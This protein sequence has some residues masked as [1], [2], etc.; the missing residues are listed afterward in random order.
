MQFCCLPCRSFIANPNNCFLYLVRHQGSSRKYTHYS[1]GTGITKESGQSTFDIL[2]P[3]WATIDNH[4]IPNL[5]GASTTIA[6]LM[7]WLAEF[8]E[9]R[10]WIGSHRPRN[11]ML[12]LMT[13]VGE[14]AEL[15]QWNGDRD[16]DISVELC[17]RLSQELGDIAIFLLRMTDLYG[18]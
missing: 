10:D 7:K 9:E 3:D 1:N 12:G 2:A 14:L 5:Y 8:A 13:E 16:S 15:V 4:D 18:M 17:D 6:R 11:L